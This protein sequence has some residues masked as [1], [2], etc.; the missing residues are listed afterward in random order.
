LRLTN[1]GD[2]QKSNFTGYTKKVTL[3]LTLLDWNKM[4]IVPILRVSD[5]MVN[6]QWHYFVFEGYA[7]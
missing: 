6:V 5:V 3:R 7:I 2:P 1:L 4:K